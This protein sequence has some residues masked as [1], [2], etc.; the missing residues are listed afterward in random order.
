[1]ANK[2]TVSISEL[3][4]IIFVSSMNEDS[5]FRTESIGSL[6]SDGEK[7]Y[8][9]YLGTLDTEELLYEIDKDLFETLVNKGCFTK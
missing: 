5:R 4:G 6:V 8:V 9:S 2:V 7:H 1:M 3:G